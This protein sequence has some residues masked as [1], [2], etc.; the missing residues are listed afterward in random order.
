M[1]IFGRMNA[2]YRDVV[3]GRVDCPLDGCVPMAACARCPW[4]A[5]L[6]IGG[7]HHQIVVCRPRVTSLAD[8]P[9]A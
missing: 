8:V 2:C 9:P 5:S 7:G 4:K 6:E 1:S 3:D